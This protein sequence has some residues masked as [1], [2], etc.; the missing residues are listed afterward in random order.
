MTRKPDLSLFTKHWLLKLLSLLI[1][2]GLWYFVV[3]EDRLDLTVTIPLE[4]RNLPANFII[5]NRYKK[6]IEV[7][8]SGPRR[9]IQEMRQQNISRPVDLSKA[10][11]GSLV[12]ENDA[13]SIPLPH[14][15]TVQRVQPASI[16]LLIDRLAR[17]EFPLVPITAGKPVAGLVLDSVTLKPPRITVTGPQTVLE[18][19][20]MLNTSVINLE[21][22]ASSTT[23][24]VRLNLNEALLNLIGETV[25]EANIVLKD[26]MLKKI[27]RGIPVYAGENG[28]PV[29]CSP[30]TVAVEADIPE[31]LVHG[32]PELF[33]LFR[34]SAEIPPNRSNDEASVQVHGISLP[35]HSPIA[36]HSVTP[37]KVR[38]LP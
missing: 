19:E 22:I 12:V 3:A 1:S 7:V 8:V 10:E 2:A 6:D 37:S 33:V 9:L 14:G 5:G 30:A 17:K 32:T 29:K 18:K 27:V 23:V 36:I 21:G 38:I 35:D 16:T 15:V 20:D 24:Q 34:A 31:R 26:N 11:P 25:I 28:P 13:D 4:L